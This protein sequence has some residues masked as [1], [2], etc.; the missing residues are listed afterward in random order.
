MKTE[1]PGLAAAMADKPVFAMGGGLDFVAAQDLVRAGAGAVRS[2]AVAC[3]LD[4]VAR[5]AEQLR[6]Q[7]GKPMPDVIRQ[8]TGGVVAIQSIEFRKSSPMP[9]R[10]EAFGMASVRSGK[11]A[12]AAAKAELP[13]LEELGLK[14]DGELR[15]IGDLLPI[16]F[17]VFGGIGERSMVFAVGTAGRK[18]A[19]RVLEAK[20]GGDKAPF[21]VASYDYGQLVTLRGQLGGLLEAESDAEAE[22]DAGLAN[23]FGRAAGS[24]D[25]GDKGLVMWG[26]VELK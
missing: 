26:S 9:S 19:R 17:D 10:L 25:I 7:V 14:T 8:V 6:H 4:D 12:F 2:V 21:M 20:G 22:L 13:L 1:V 5:D 11:A 16:P 23:M 15:P 3:E 24:I 18:L